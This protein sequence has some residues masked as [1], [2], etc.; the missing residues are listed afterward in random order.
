MAI[1]Q[2]PREN[3]LLEAT[4]YTRRSLFRVPRASRWTAPWTAT[5]GSAD[6]VE[7]V[8]QAVPH[9]LL[10]WEWLAPFQQRAEWELF[11]G[12]R[13]DARWSIYFDEQPVLQFNR[14]NQLRRLFA[15]NQRYAAN[16]GRLYRLERQHLGGQVQ[17]QQV[18][19]DEAS[20]GSVLNVCQQFLGEAAQALR[21]GR[22]RRIGEFPADD[23]A[24]LP[25]FEQNLQRVANGFSIA[26]SPAH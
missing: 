7:G 3:L 22:A 12:L 18:E 2:H 20:Q 1:H 6:R 13:A 21:S 14:Q 24:W 26:A 9:D 16:N 11:I 15:E 10:L 5:K 23:T 25:A 17:L 8:E 19:L 4:A